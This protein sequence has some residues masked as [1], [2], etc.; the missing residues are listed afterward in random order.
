MCEADVLCLSLRLALFGM[1]LAQGIESN[2]GPGPGSTGSS[3]GSN[4]GGSVRG[5]GT[6]CGRGGTGGG[7]SGR[8]F[9]SAEPDDF[10]ADVPTSGQKR[11]VTRSSQ[12]VNGAQSSQQQSISNWLT[13]Q[14]SQQGQ[15]ESRHVSPDRSATDTDTDIDQALRMVVVSDRSEA[16]L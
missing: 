9:S 12:I 4:S 10:F 15:N 7:V 8:A 5:R 11:R 2:P 16:C 13:S 1:L 3:R 6:G 14:P